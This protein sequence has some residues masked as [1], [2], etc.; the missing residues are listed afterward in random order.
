MTIFGKQR[1]IFT[2]WFSLYLNKNDLSSLLIS[3]WLLMFCSFVFNL[4]QNECYAVSLR[5]HNDSSSVEGHAFQKVN[6]TCE[7]CDWQPIFY[8]LVLLA[9]SCLD[10]PNVLRPVACWDSE[11]YYPSSFFKKVWLG[12]GKVHCWLEQSFLFEKSVI[13]SVKNISKQNNWQFQKSNWACC[14]VCS[15]LRQSLEFALLKE[16]SVP[17]SVRRS[18][19]VWNQQLMFRFVYAC[20]KGIV[21]W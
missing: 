1:K 20:V 16:R 15:L 18:Q 6:V 7:R 21:A 3:R 13:L 5:T 14:G 10:F 2:V 8:T 12:D 9:P 17:E 19:H 4:R 11:A